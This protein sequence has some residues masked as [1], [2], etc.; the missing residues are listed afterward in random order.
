MANEDIPKSPGKGAKPAYM[1]G[2]N[3][4]NRTNANDSKT[5]QESFGKSKQAK[6]SEKPKKDK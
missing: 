5:T 2:T 4:S 1:T 6:T 3:Q